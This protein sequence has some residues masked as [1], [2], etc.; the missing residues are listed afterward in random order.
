MNT[1]ENLIWEAYANKDTSE[2]IPGPQQSCK[3]GEYFC[4]KDKICKPLEEAKMDPV[5]KE[6]DDI[7]NDGK[8]DKTDDYLKNRREKVSSAIHNKN[9][10]KKEQVDEEMITTYEDEEPSS[11]NYHDARFSPD[12]MLV[13]AEEG[14]LRANAESGNVRDYEGVFKLIN[15]VLDAVGSAVMA[16]ALTEDDT[17][18]NPIENEVACREYSLCQGIEDAIA[19]NFNPKDIDDIF[20]QA[21]AS[22][23]DSQK[24]LDGEDVRELSI[25]ASD[26]EPNPAL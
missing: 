6:D 3:K 8:K 4:E 12:G 20:R 19:S 21:C 5:G 25:H 1:E 9:D 15:S 24:Q 7:N 2:T 22:Y 23:R 17:R 26:G 13:D 16:N 14:I 11:Y 18:G 10:D